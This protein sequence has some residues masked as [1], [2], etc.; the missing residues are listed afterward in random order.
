[1]CNNMKIEAL[2][3]AFFPANFAF[4]VEI[5][6]GGQ[7]S[8]QTGVIAWYL[9]NTWRKVANEIARKLMDGL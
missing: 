6:G 8:N 1:M 3:L 7:I 4:S 5:R 9:S 2:V